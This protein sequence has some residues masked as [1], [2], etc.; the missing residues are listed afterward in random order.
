MRSQPDSDPSCFSIPEIC[1]REYIHEFTTTSHNGNDKITE[2]IEDFDVETVKEVEQNNLEPVDLAVLNEPIVSS[3]V[4]T[5]DGNLA[6]DIQ[7]TNSTTPSSTT[8]TTTTLSSTTTNE[9]TTSSPSTTTTTP[10]TTTSLP[11]TTTTLPQSTTTQSTTTAT[12]TNVPSTTP[13]TTITTTTSETSTLPSTTTS[14]TTEATTTSTLP[15]TTTTPIPTTT[16]T[17]TIPL[18]ATT[19]TTLA[20]PSSTTT[21]L[22]T[23]EATTK[24]L[25][26][27]TSP[28]NTSTTS[29]PSSTT[30]EITM[31]STTLI[32]TIS[33]TPSTPS[34]TGT[35]HS[36]TTLPPST[37]TLSTTPIIKTPS[38][39]TTTT[40]IQTSTTAVPIIT[41]TVTISPS[42][43]TKPVVPQTKE[44]IL[45]NESSQQSKINLVF[46]PSSTTT[47]SPTTFV[48]NVSAF[49]SVVATIQPD[50]KTENF[51]TTSFSPPTTNVFTPTTARAP[52]ST[53]P[54]TTPTPT[55]TPPTT[56]ETA[57][58]VTSTAFPRFLST[59][60][61]FA[62]NSNRTAK[63]FQQLSSQ[64]VEQKTTNFIPATTTTVS[65]TTSTPST[66]APSPSTIASI[67][68]T[69]NF[70]NANTTQFFQQQPSSKFIVQQQASIQT[71][72]TPPST[73]TTT[74]T[75]PA[76][77]IRPIERTTPTFGRFVLST[78]QSIDIKTFDNRTDI[79][80]KIFKQQKIFSEFIRD[81]TLTTRNI[82]FTTPEENKIIVDK[83][84]QKLDETVK[85]FRTA[86]PPFGFAFA[87]SI[88]PKRTT[89]STTP[90][91]LSTTFLERTVTKMPRHFAD[92]DLPVPST[93]SSLPLTIFAKNRIEQFQRN[94]PQ[95]INNNNNNNDFQQIVFPTT[96]STR[97]TR[98][99]TESQ[100][101]VVVD[102][103]IFGD[104]FG[105]NFLGL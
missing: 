18:T 20:L 62:F 14:T 79:L 43:T 17:T 57:R 36:T 69:K 68:S 95:R 6:N 38:T 59:A 65:S 13:P 73:T 49:V 31:P 45:N 92:R 64:N 103:E 26:T 44:N 71:S 21:I 75:T 50:I 74:T 10:K 5:V 91:F 51:V 40:T 83:R 100:Q 94:L 96:T 42:L 2:V 60:R 52:F 98:A 58:L 89:R 105:I 53:P 35:T 72:S 33:S 12:T 34:S 24:L 82:P 56:T 86:T 25:S 11:T 15:S 66:R 99:T 85:R 48:R 101:L 3:N 22:T 84:L 4:E 81:S 61:F 77:F 37:T 93:P 54:T 1:L 41:G 39:T 8:S 78:A 23:A 80:R 7:T 102:G 90:E 16:S 19:T 46:S 70:D 27:T 63:P 88:P 9:I 97:A 32:T 30:I 67:L 76:V 104:H 29:T 28:T 47:M 55:P 87:S